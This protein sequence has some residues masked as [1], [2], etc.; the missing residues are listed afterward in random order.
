MKPGR[1]V[2]IKYENC[3]CEFCFV[4]KHGGKYKQMLGPSITVCYIKCTW[5]CCIIR[6][7]R[8]EKMFIAR[9]LRLFYYTGIFGAWFIERVHTIFYICGRSIV[10]LHNIL[11]I[12]IKLYSK[13]L[14]LPLLV[15][16]IQKFFTIHQR[17]IYIVYLGRMRMKMR[18]YIG[19]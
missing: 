4:L 6:W 7:V 15:F 3:S 2:I 11:Y 1:I 5:Q 8:E 18:E 10:S 9:V 13:I 16:Y 17:G 12:Y 14:Y 19:E